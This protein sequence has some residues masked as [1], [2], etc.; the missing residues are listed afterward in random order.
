M[1]KIERMREEKRGGEKEE[2]DGRR[3]GRRT[4]MRREGQG[5]GR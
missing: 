5:E 3:T 2:N 4:N 1:K